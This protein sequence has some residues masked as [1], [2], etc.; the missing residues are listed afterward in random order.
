M[1]TTKQKRHGLT[2]IGNEQALVVNYRRDTHCPVIVFIRR[3]N[4]GKFV[5]A[6]AW[7]INLSEDSCMVSSD[8]FPKKAYEIRIL[9]PGLSDKIKGKVQ[10]QGD[11]TINVRFNFELPTRI[12]NR[13]ARINK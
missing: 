5:Q 3:A 12:V 11:Y 13:I 4:E 8:N 9:F 1:N 6:P 7:L 10:N 2:Q